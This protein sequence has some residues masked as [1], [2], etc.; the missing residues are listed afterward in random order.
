MIQCRVFVGTMIAVTLLSL[1]AV[2]FGKI[3]SGGSPKG[4]INKVVG[5]VFALMGAM[6]F[7]L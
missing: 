1:I 7:I 6:F 3:I 5:I 2:F 4:T